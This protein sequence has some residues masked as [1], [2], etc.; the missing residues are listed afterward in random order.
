[1]FQGFLLKGPH[2]PS[3]EPSRVEV[4]STELKRSSKGLTDEVLFIPIARYSSL[5]NLER[6]KQR[7]NQPQHKPANKKRRSNVLRRFSF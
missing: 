4:S 6:G 2:G 7:G 5:A 1:M 3:E